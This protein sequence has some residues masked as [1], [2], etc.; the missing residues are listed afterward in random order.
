MQTF[1]IENSTQQNETLSKLQI[2]KINQSKWIT[3][4]T[5]IIALI[6]TFL[7]LF[8][9]YS[10]LIINGILVINQSIALYYIIKTMKSKLFMSDEYNKMIGNKFRLK[11]IV[12]VIIIDLIISCGVF[13]ISF[14][15]NDEYER[16]FACV[17]VL[18]S[19][20]KI[21]TIYYNHY[22]I[23]EIEKMI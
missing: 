19:L 20:M 14:I 5:L 10:T 1:S 11:I 21:G 8:L 22:L 18:I 6:E 2:L 17:Y 4:F 23:G 13:Y 3:I 15:S 9:S 16:Y 12:I 7:F